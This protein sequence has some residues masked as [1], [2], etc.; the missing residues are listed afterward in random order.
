MLFRSR[1]GSALQT[2]VKEATAVE[3]RGVARR[4]RGFELLC[5]CPRLHAFQ[6]IVAAFDC[7]ARIVD[8]VVLIQAGDGVGT[9]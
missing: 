6:Q 3:L 4:F 1:E 7:G 2:L 8:L 9:E 5:D